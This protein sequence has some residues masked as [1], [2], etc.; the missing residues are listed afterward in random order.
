MA[1]RRQ[2]PTEDMSDGYTQSSVIAHSDL[3]I[4][5]EPNWEGDIAINNYKLPL[6]HF[7]HTILI[8]L[9]MMTMMKT[10]K[11]QEWNRVEGSDPQGT[12]KQLTTHGG[13]PV[14]ILAQADQ[15]GV[16]MI[17][18][19]HSQWWWWWPTSMIDG[20]M[21]QTLIKDCTCNVWRSIL[22]FTRPSTVDYRTKIYIDWKRRNVFFLTYVSPKS[23]FRCLERKLW[24]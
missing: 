15:L 12:H 8:M 1:P 14:I 19:S 24:K 22:E 23:T 17:R 4:C 21:W 16:M 20:D 10:K 9:I 6:A 18:W 2:R 5:G 7:G 13:R 3:C 11:T